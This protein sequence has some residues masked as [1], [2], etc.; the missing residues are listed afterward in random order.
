MSNVQSDSSALS[1]PRTRLESGLSGQAQI[2]FCD[3]EA[4]SRHKSFEP[5]LATEPDL[6]LSLLEKLIHTN[7]YYKKMNTRE[8]DTNCIVVVDK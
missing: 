2:S 5:K 1:R 7:Q 3:L 8:R 4:E 6:A